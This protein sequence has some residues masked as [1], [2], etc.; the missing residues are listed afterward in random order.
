M[1]R[2]KWFVVLALAALLQT[3]SAVTI[4]AISVT[5][6]TDNVLNYDFTYS[7]ITNLFSDTRIQVLGGVNGLVDFNLV[8]SGDAD[9]PVVHQIG[10]IKNLSTVVHT[11]TIQVGI[12]LGFAP[13]PDSSVL[14]P[15]T[16]AISSISGTLTDG[17]GDGGATLATIRG[18]H[19]LVPPGPSLNID[20]STICLA[21]L[22]CG[23]GKVTDFGP[24]VFDNLSF[25]LQFSLDPNDSFSY[26]TFVQLTNVPEPSSLLLLLSGLAAVSYLRLRK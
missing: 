18:F 1:L 21:G 22:A 8:S 23:S 10:T 12:P 13:D 19:D 4:G 15:F 20:A 6:N 14:G 5:V 26:E 16:R 9:D 25:Q 3:A 17:G 11:Y 2:V 7:P 24:T